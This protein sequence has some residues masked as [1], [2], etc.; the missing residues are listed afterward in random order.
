MAKRN[1][2][3]QVRRNTRWLLQEIGKNWTSAAGN[4]IN[5]SIQFEP[6]ER[7]ELMA[8]DFFASTANLAAVA[9]TS[10]MAPT[11]LQ[12]TVLTSGLHGEGEAAPDLVG[13]A[14]ALTAANAKFYGADWCP[15]CTDQKEL[16]AEG[17]NYL[18]FVEVTNPDR[19]PNTIATQ[20]NIT[21]YPTWKFANGQ[22]A[23][24]IQ[25]LEQLST[26][27]GVAIPTSSDP[28]FVEIP[29]QTVLFRSPLHIPV[30]TYDPNGGP[31]TVVVESSNPSIISAE[32]VTNPKSVRVVVDNFGEMVFRLFPTE[33]P[34]AVARFEELVNDGFY[35][36]MSA[37]ERI[38]FHR[39][40]DNFV[41]QAGDP[42]GT[43]SGGSSLG[44]FD[45]QFNVNLQHNRTGVLSYAK[46]SDD[47]NDSQFFITEGPQRHLDFNHSIFGQLVEG[48]AVRQAISRTAV[49]S[50]RPTNDVVINSMEIF[51]D[52][53]NG[54]IRL[55]SQGTTGSSTI[56][57][58]VT[59]ATG[60][61]F[62]RTFVATAAAD[63]TNG[64]PFL[65][66]ITVPAIAPGQTVNI[67]LTAQ[68]KEGDSIFYDA[69]RQGSVPY[70][71]NVNN[72]TGLLSVTAPQN[73]TGPFSLAVGVRA[74]SASSTSDLFDTQ[75]ITFN[76]A[77]T[78]SAPTGVD[79]LAITDSGVSDSDNITN[80]GNMQF[81]ISGTT[82]GATVE[83]KVGSQVIG[84][85]QATG[86]TTT[87]TS[88][89]GSLLG[90]GTY[91][92]VATQTISGQTS[93]SSP[94]L[95]VTFDN[96]P[97]VAIAAS[98]LPTQANVGNELRVD[99]VHPDEGNGLRY[100]L[101]NAP[102]GMTI[103]S[104]TGELVWT[105]TTAQLGPQTA[106]LRLLD[107]AG[108]SQAQVMAINVAETALIGVQLQVLSTTGSPLTSLT[109]NQEFNLRIVVEDLRVG[110]S[111]IGDGVFSAYMD[112]V[113]DAAKVELVGT[114][115]ITFDSLFGNGRASDIT[116]LGVIEEVGA[117]SSQTNGPGR[118]PQ[119]VFTVRMRAK[120]G[121]TAFF[122]V[123][124]AETA[125][126]GFAVFRQD[127]AVPSARVGFGT[128]TVAIAQ[129][130]TV[131][132]DVVSV[133]E[134]STNTTINVLAN[135]TIVPGSNAVLTV[136]S[137][138]AT[139]QGGTVSIA[140]NG[141]SVLYQ[142]PA[143]FNGV[144][145]FTYTVRD[146]SGATETGT[147]TV[148]VQ[149][150]NDNPVATNDSITTV[151]SGDSNVFLDVLSNDNSGPDTG[152]T[153]RVTAVGTASQ[154]GTVQIDNNGIGVRYTPRSGFVGLE[155]FTYTIG[156]G[157]GG[158]STATVS[159]QVGPAV[160]PP[161]VVGESFTVAEDSAAV[162]Y[163]VLTNDV[164]A[165]S[166]DTLTVTNVT[167]TSGTVSVVNN[168]TQVRYVP[169]ANFS[170]VDRVIYTVRGSNGG[171]ATGTMTMTVTAVND[172]PTAV[173]DTAT[174]LSIP[175]Q[176][177]NVLAN[178]INVDTGETLTI[179]AVTQ[180]PSG[181]GTVVI[182]ADGKSLIY[183]APSTSFT[184][185]VEFQYTLG[186]GSGLTATASVRLT[187]VNFTP[188]D[189][190]VT[191][192]GPVQGVAIEV[193]QLTGID[194]VP[195]NASANVTMVGNVAQVNDTGPGTY[196]FTVP[197]L[198]FFVA[199]ASSAD[200][201]S[202][203]ADGNNVATPL[204][205]G[206]RDPRF[207]DLRDFSSK[208]LSKGITVAVQPSHS[209][210]WYDGIRDWRSFS[211]VNVSLNNTA[212]QLTIQTVDASNTTRQATL[213]TSDPRVV[214]RGKDGDNHLFRIQAAPSELNFTAVPNTTNNT[215]ST[216]GLAGGEG[217]GSAGMRS[218]VPMLRSTDVDAAMA[219]PS[220]AT[221]SMGLDQAIE[222]VAQAP[223]RPVSLL[224]FRTRR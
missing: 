97:P 177:V 206:V 102:A 54:L 127:T 208:N 140:S 147:V 51:N 55:K 61:T 82:A 74:A 80:V 146:Q 56:T 174:V 26:L 124:P 117:F 163:S 7:R 10:N 118:D 93:A 108:N 137:V 185:A 6:L 203:F 90:A 91:A 58:R 195:V 16:F 221:P 48:E 14:K 156:D 193:M 186:D 181:R 175:N 113:Y 133:N 36:E 191:Q 198:P 165:Q 119:T 57:V 161:T 71:F 92:V 43:G 160:P 209:A 32:L 24:G 183:S 69:S 2:R 217:E 218:A 45:D 21:S 66:D 202:G 1:R 53:Q 9:G 135:D 178:D 212:S 116:T 75:T 83:L 49:S 85:A 8:T 25:T 223:G 34:R 197:N 199:D 107:V 99:L 205:V 128:A 114:S 79:L 87:I 18:P 17:A 143:N 189:V 168:S 151:R 44:P 129:N 39:V 141:T 166:G 65:N 111:G 38:I 67:Q 13:F 164:P 188:R 131:S 59:N 211:S 50:S 77:G 3:F 84:S 5:R 214:L 139:S 62:T 162:D 224:D 106:T 96:T 130:F 144:D 95:N 138:S 154:G 216:N 89:V 132:P 94:V 145:T 215:S 122:S 86:A 112:L 169:N 100:V 220:I 105:P 70:V 180:P 98:G 153:L 173:S 23:T 37:T 125:G 134:D 136:Q 11:A 192:T 68:D 187:V 150:I 104:Q 219:T 28:T 201:V 179:T 207:M 171:T 60:Q 152:E 76:V 30:D 148:N 35:D 167:A 42:T 210:L 159:V 46:S 64:S 27:S 184:G 12:S 120:V 19:S 204:S 172:A 72:S 33:A 31:L 149:P 213:A 176:T 194:G 20:Q 78:S 41:I 103:N 155:T 22:V 182:A 73:F 52:N 115:P 158:T 157:N 222:Q 170:G 63:T 109:L 123:N 190:G 110:G 121:G 40:I 4:R 142:P 88:N 29:D 101:E 196:R 47:T 81:T 200:V 126:R 15:H